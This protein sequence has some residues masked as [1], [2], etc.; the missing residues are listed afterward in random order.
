MKALAAC[1]AALACPLATAVTWHGTDVNLQIQR[2]R[3][4]NGSPVHTL[5]IFS[6]C[7]LYGTVGGGGGKYLS[8]TDV[9]G[10]CTY[11]Q[12]PTSFSS[13]SP[14]YFTMYPT[15]MSVT[16]PDG[17]LLHSWEDHRRITVDQAL[18]GTSISVLRY[19]CSD[20]LL[21]SSFDL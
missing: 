20:T 13:P 6:G 3:T 7:D 9:W 18:T 11:H 1:L 14:V 21:T 15:R 12:S 10:H 17:G 5:E 2:T 8:M 19:D 4:Q 16:Y